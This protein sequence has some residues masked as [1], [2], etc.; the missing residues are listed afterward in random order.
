MAMLESVHDAP[1]DTTELPAGSAV[2]VRNRF[3]QSWS[4][5]FEISEIVAVPV[6]RSY[7]IR[8]MSD[9]SVLPDLFTDDTVRR[10]A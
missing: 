3:T 9:G 6:P 10:C 7:R 5:G 8:R 2:E 4:G 1:P